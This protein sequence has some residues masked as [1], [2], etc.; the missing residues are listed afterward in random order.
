MP[1]GGP[2]FGRSLGSQTG[3]SSGCSF[4]HQLWHPSRGWQSAASEF[5]TAYRIPHTAYRHRRLGR[6]TI[7][8]VL[9]RDLLV[10]CTSS[11]MLCSEESVLTCYLR[12]PVPRYS[13]LRRFPLETWLAGGGRVKNCQL[14]HCW[15]CIQEKAYWAKKKIDKA[16]K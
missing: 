1:S 3:H 10:P 2:M 16:K 13:I 7:V 5:G 8:W 15:G 14:L 11:W 12:I 6:G 4:G 9:L